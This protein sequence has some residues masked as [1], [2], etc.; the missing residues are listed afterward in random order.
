MWAPPV[1]PGP[2]PTT[3]PA[4]S[5]ELARARQLAQGAEHR[6][7]RALLEKKLR[8]GKANREEASILMDACGAL[9]DKAC[10]EA[11]KVKHPEVDLP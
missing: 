4:V 1:E 8:A 9:R 2:A 10:I 11:V 7:V 6:K 5:P 3:A